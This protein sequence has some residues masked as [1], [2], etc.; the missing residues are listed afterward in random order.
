MI[1][2]NLQSR[3]GDESPSILGAKILFP[4]KQEIPLARE[5]TDVVA[6]VYIRGSWIRIEALRVCHIYFFVAGTMFQEL[7]NR[8]AVVKK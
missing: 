2:V 1:W 3:N 6:Q 4:A 5:S 8:K 7:Q